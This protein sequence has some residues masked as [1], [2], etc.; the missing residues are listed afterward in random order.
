MKLRNSPRSTLTK[1]DA[2]SI[3]KAVSGLSMTSFVRGR[4]EVVFPQYQM[5]WKKWCGE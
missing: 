3:G 2:E 4:L 1:R 5:Q